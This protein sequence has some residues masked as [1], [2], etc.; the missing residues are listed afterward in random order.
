M[1]CRY[2]NKIDENGC[3]LCECNPGPT[4]CDAD[5]RPECP[6][7]DAVCCDDGRWWCSAS[8]GPMACVEKG[9]VCRDDCP[10]VMCTLYCEYGFELGPDGCEICDCKEPP[11]SACCSAAAEPACQHGAGCCADGTWSCLRL[12]GT[13]T[14]E[15]KGEVCAVTTTP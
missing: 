15:D 7:D 12:D 5:N 14:C 4:C 2:G 11:A 9:E 6:G 10:G 8:M 1:F 3:E 13:S